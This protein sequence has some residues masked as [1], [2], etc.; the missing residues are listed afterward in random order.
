MLNGKKTEEKNSESRGIDLL[1]QES[2]RIEKIR[3]QISS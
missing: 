2:Y 3:G 1:K